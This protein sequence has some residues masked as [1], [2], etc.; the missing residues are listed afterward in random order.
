MLV[1]RR[2]LQPEKG[3]LMVDED[4]IEFGPMDQEVNEI[5]LEKG[6]SHEDV[7]C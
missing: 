5:S 3:V 6:S 4:E 2:N 7:D 1:L